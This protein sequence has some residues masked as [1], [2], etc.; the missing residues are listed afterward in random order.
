ME[1]FL[2]VFKHGVHISESHRRA[3]VFSSYYLFILP[4]SDMSAVSPNAL[5]HKSKHGHI[6][7]MTGLRSYNWLTGILGPYCYRKHDPKSSQLWKKRPH[8]YDTATKLM[9]YTV[10]LFQCFLPIHSHFSCCLYV[11]GR[12]PVGNL[13]FGILGKMLICPACSSG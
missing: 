10:W 13:P 7:L 5:C 6:T 1:A 3:L 12:S 2:F 11:V 9:L 4:L 8:N